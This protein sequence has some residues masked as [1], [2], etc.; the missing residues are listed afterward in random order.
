MSEIERNLINALREMK[1][2]RNGEF[3]A[4]SWH[5]MIER[6]KAEIK[7]ETNESTHDPRQR[8]LTTW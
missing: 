8:K 5:G 3:E 1:Q 6:I 2:I 7:E 4:E